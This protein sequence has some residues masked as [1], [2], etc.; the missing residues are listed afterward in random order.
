MEVKHYR[1]YSRELGQDFELKAYGSSGKP[2]LAFPTSCGRFFDYENNGMTG[3]MAEF[4]DRGDVAVF[5]VDGRDAET[6]YKPVRDEWMGRRHAQYEACI[7]RETVPFLREACG[8]REKFLATGNSFGAFHSANFFFKFPD[9]FDSALCLS[10]LYAIKGELGGYSDP[11]VS[12][13]EPLSYLPGLAEGA[14]LAALRAGY[15]VIAHGGGAWENFNDQASALASVCAVKGI[16]CWYDPWGGEW[17]H[18][19]HTWHAQ[20][21][22]YLAQFREGVL[23]PRGPVKLTG[24]GR[25]VNLLG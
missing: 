18:E 9:V 17:S 3:A 22:K 25:R 4:I 5:A 16:P 24:P 10:G 21:K 7:L 20:I 23:T 13:N 1:F 12:A 14:R 15:L 8:V 2:V 6:W 11:A 19:W